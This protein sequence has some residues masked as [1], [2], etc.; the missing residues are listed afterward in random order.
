MAS[1]AISAIGKTHESYV[2]SSLQ[3]RLR[4]GYKKHQA[5]KAEHRENKPECYGHNVAMSERN[6][7]VVSACRD[8][9]SSHCKIAAR[10]ISVFFQK[11]GLYVSKGFCWLGWGVCF[12]CPEAQNSIKRTIDKLQRKIDDLTGKSD[13]VSHHERAQAEYDQG[14]YISGIGHDIKA[15]VK[16]VKPRIKTVWTSIKGQFK[17]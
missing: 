10:K 12:C 1:P 3:H 4:A 17:G 11:V 15:G 6:S 13:A 16:R 5:K 14:N 9:F 2:G 8:K 7:V